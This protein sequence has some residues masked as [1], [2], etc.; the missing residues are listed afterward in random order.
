MCLLNVLQ[1]L[2]PEVRVIEFGVVPT[3]HQQTV[4]RPL[5]DDP[6]G[7]LDRGRS[8]RRAQR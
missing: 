1:A 6:V 3:A 2:V 5:F 8:R 4:V 7:A